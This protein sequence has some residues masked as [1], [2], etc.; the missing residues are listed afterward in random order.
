[1]NVEQSRWAAVA[2]VLVVACVSCMTSSPPPNTADLGV[3]SGTPSN[4]LCCVDPTPDCRIPDVPCDESHP[5]CAF[6]AENNSG[7]LEVADPDS[8]RDGAWICVCRDDA[9]CGAGQICLDFECG[10]ANNVPS[11]TADVGADQGADV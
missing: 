4:E 3:D 8:G 2:V 10:P 7:K 11:N 1:M 9:D 5:V 6:V